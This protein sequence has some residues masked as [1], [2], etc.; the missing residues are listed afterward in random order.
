VRSV[1]KE[2][3]IITTSYIDN[4]SKK[5]EENFIITSFFDNSEVNER[6]HCVSDPDPLNPDPG[7]K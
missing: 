5:Q 6:Y 3:N 2:Y 7:F 1:K 4:T